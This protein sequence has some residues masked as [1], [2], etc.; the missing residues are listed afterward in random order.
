MDC[1]IGVDT[2]AYCVAEGAIPMEME[3]LN[4]ALSVEPLRAPQQ[5]ATVAKRFCGKE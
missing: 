2:E 1:V 5:L 4:D 3:A